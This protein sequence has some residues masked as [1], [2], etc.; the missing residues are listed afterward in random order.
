MALDM[1]INIAAAKDA[2]DA[3]VD[4]LDGTGAKRAHVRIYGIT[5]AGSIPTTA[6]AALHST[7]MPELA[8]VHFPNPA[9][10]DAATGTAN[11]ASATASSS[12]SET[13]AVS[14]TAKFFRAYTDAAAATTA[15]IIQGTC[16]TTSS[17]DMNMNTDAIAT[18]ATVTITS[19]KIK[20]KMG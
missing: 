12:V 15:A 8:D 11:S 1:K 20:L 2:L 6:A 3:I 14:G 17:F 10:G 4:S 18:G 9:F 16:G 7:S 5:G 13:S 19:W